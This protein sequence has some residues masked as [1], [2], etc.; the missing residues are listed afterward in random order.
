MSFAYSTTRLLHDEHE[1][2]LVLL[3]RT[4][5]AL[6]RQDADAA[7]I[8]SAARHLAHALRGEITEHFTFEEQFV[9]PRLIERGCGDIVELLDEEHQTLNEAFAEILDLIAPL[10]AALTA[11]LDVTRFRRLFGVVDTGLR[12]HIEKEELGLL[13]MIEEFFDRDLDAEAASRHGD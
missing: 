8:V 1:A 5:S 10:E 11:D 2:A 9:F 13:R 7:A 12:G 6:R 4:A 3:E